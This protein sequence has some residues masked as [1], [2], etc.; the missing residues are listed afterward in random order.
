M[1]DAPVD[2]YERSSYKH[3]THPFVRSLHG[4]IFPHRIA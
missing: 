3:V 4:R 1:Q 2:N